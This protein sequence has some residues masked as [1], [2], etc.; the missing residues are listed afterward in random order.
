MQPTKSV[1]VRV[2]DTL[3]LEQCQTVLAA[4]LAKAGCRACCSGVNISF[5]SAVA[6]LTVD[7]NSLELRETV[8]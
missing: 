4:V 6:S 3:D 7:P 1:T 5:E 8:G 2:P